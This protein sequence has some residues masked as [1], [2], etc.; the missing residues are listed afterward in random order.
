ML[1]L[2]LNEELVANGRTVA[3]ATG[4]QLRNVRMDIRSLDLPGQ[5]DHSTSVCVFEHL[6]ISGRIRT[7]G[8][9]RGLLRDG[10]SFSMT[11]DYLNPSRTASIDS[12][13]DVEEH[14]VRPSG[15]RVR[16]NPIFYD[17]GKRYLLHPAHHRLAART[18]WR[19][20]YVR[21]GELEPD[22]A[23]RVSESNDYT[24][25]AL[26]MERERTEPGISRD[27][28]CD[29]REPPRPC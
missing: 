17:N 21:L 16:G 10:G 28:G 15:L 25:G 26:F 29:L 27:E 22:D 5:F 3:K 13:A 7:S 18:G 12:P 23:A 11:F 2:D 9:V 4:W 6:P 19:E 20:E 1:A 14:F 24:F 8:Q